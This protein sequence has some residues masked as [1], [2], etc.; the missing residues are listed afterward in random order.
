MQ[1]DY[2]DSALCRLSEVEV[3]PGTGIDFEG[4]ARD[5][6]YG[7]IAY[8]VWWN[9]VRKPLRSFFIIIN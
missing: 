8:V 7:V 5:L 3:E 1:R 2:S 9:Y 4:D 6:F